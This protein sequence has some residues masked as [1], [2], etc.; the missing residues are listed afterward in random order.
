[1][2]FELSENKTKNLEKKIHEL[3][4]EVER[5]NEAIS[6]LF[7]EIGCTPEEL[8][9]FLKNPENF[10]P[11]EFEILKELQRLVSEKSDLSLSAHYSPSQN[12]QKMEERKEV[13]PHWIFC[14]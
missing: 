2:F 8:H 1:M 14:R 5:Q 10:S 12:K 13:A 4:L 3:T 6:K 7:I 11:Q 9:L